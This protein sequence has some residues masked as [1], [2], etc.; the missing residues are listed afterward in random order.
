MLIS[1]TLVADL[2]LTRGILKGPL[3]KERK[4]KQNL[5]SHDLKTNN[6]VT[7]SVPRK[8]SL[9]K[10]VIR[11]RKKMRKSGEEEGRE[12]NRKAEIH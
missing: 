3:K 6:L 1:A 5:K 11:S 10:H 9:W 4:K 12:E 2:N 7:V 8:N